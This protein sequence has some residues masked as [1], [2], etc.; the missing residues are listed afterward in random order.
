MQAPGEG[1]AGELA[2]PV[3]VEEFRRAVARQRKYFVFR[4]TR[5]SVTA[6][7]YDLFDYNLAASFRM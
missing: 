5:R 4:G 1:K 7:L 3:G 2:A 6:L